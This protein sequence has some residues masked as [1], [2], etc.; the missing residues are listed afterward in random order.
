MPLTSTSRAFFWQ[1]LAVV[2]VLGSFAAPR[3]AAASPLPITGW[4]WGGTNTISASLS[5][6]FVGWISFSGTA[7]DSSTYGVYEDS[8]T[9]ALSGRAWSSNLG[10]ITFNSAEVSSCP[11]APC[12]P[13]VNLSTG[14][15]TGWARACAA[16]AGLCSG[17]LDSNSAVPTAWDGWISLRNDSD[18]DGIV[19][20]DTGAAIA[21]FGVIQTPATC[22]AWSGYAW[23][24]DSIGAISMSGSAYGAGCIGNPDLTAGAVSTSPVT[25]PVSAIAG[26]ATTLSSTITNTGTGSTGAVF[27]NLF[28]FDND[29]D[30]TTV[31]AATTDTSP[32]VAAGGTD[33]SQVS[34]T[35]SAPGTWYVRACADNNASF[36]GTITE[37][38]ASPKGEFDNCGEWIPVTVASALSATLSASQYTIDQGQSSTL[39]WSSTGGA[40]SCEAAGGGTWLSVGSSASGS[41]STGPL[42]D[43]AAYQVRCIKGSDYA[44]SNIVPIDVVLA[45]AFISARPT[46]IG[47]GGSSKIS[48]GATQVLSCSV[49]GP[50]LS[51]TLTTGFQIVP[52]SVRSTYTISCTTNGDPIVKSVIVGVSSCWTEF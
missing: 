15:I 25:S 34:Y 46:C 11:S 24:S 9:G 14:A 42:D 45:T 21:D 52:I 8:A 23:G 6:S 2:F 44:Y 20:T 41:T 28:Q 43:S 12:A 36:V 19:N 27:T 37:P 30:H 13:S 47:S 26:I 18:S 1:L 32:T 4:A 49:S 51:S 38:Q 40:T 7:A 50:G 39:T 10:W 3:T 16:F 5:D 22:G 33:V 17:A 29:S 35:F 48:W 31:T